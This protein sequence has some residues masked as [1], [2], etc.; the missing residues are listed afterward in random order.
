M[1][2]LK[3]AIVGLGLVVAFGAACAEK[4]GKKK[5]DAADKEK[6]AAGAKARAG[7]KAG[8]DD[9]KKDESPD[10]ESEKD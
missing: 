1:R 10:P 5:D 2:T 3:A 8:K 9:A 6:K 7:E 4:P